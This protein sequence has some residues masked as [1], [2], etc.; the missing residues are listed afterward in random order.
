MANVAI[1]KRWYDEIKGRVKM[2]NE[3]FYTSEVWGEEVEVDVDEEEFN[4]VSTELGW[5]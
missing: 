1:T 2:E 3:Y 4:R 5:M